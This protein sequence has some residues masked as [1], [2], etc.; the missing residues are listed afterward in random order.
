[1]PYTGLLFI[2]AFLVI[3]LVNF[4]FG[5]QENT[6]QLYELLGVVFSQWH[7]ILIYMLALVG[8]AFHISHGFQSA[9]TSLG[10]NHPRYT[11]KIKVLGYLFAGV[12]FVVFGIIP[13][14]F[15]LNGGM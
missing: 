3:H 2:A 5:D 13:V 4:R 12:V 11:P 8:L 15:Y 1:M 7:W 6:E 9:F 10:L 14:L